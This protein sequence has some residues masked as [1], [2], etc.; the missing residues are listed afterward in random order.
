[1]TL[2]FTLMPLLMVSELATN[3]VVHAGTTFGLSIERTDG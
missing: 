1:M 2:L 3:A